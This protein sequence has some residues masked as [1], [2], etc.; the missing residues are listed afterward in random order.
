L[1]IGDAS[2]GKSWKVKTTANNCLYQ[3]TL[4]SQGDW[5]SYAAISDS[6]EKQN[7]YTSYRDEKAKA[8]YI[9]NSSDRLFIIYDDTLSVRLKTR[10]A[11]D[12]NLGGIML[13]EQS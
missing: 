1:I 9:F 6:M 10:Y 4:D 8:A 3:S 7:G 11:I 12:I 13:W 5:L 2:Y